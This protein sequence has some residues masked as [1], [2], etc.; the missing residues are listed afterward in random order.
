MLGFIRLIPTPF[1]SETQHIE[2]YSILYDPFNPTYCY[3]CRPDSSPF[4][5][6]NAFWAA[7]TV[8]LS[9]VSGR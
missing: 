2:R 5:A 7:V 1:W 6:A 3:C 8:V 9:G 4:R